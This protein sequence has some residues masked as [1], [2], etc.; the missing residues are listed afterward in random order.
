MP[1]TR[2]LR[3]R[4]AWVVV[5]ALAAWMLLS[6]GS[7]TSTP[8]GLLVV[9]AA[10]SAPGAFTPPTAVAHSDEQRPHLDHK[11][12]LTVW[13]SAWA[14]V[15]QFGLAG[16]LLLFV[17]CGVLLPWRSTRSPARPVG[18]IGACGARAPPPA[19]GGPVA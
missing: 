12:H 16:G 7:G 10:N 6:V 19:R 8:R 14:G 9:G 4:A 18:P 15:D 11:A 13:F 17:L 5:I 2:R 1:T 3:T